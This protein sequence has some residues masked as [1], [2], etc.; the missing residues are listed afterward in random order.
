[1]KQN[2]FKECLLFGLQGEKAFN[3]R[4][5]TFFKP[6]IK[7]ILFEKN[8]NMQRAG[9][10]SIIENKRLEDI[11]LEIK[12]RDKTYWGYNDILLETI[13]NIKTHKKGWIHSF[14]SDYL[15]YFWYDAIIDRILDAYLLQGE[16]L[17]KWVTDGNLKRYKPKQ[18]KSND[19]EVE[20][21]TEFVL[22]PISDFHPTIITRV[23]KKYLLPFTQNQKGLKEF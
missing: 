19:N 4:G 17:R 8:P 16:L 18:T 6:I 9:I 14:E 23:D 3:E 13:S 2:N 10:D 5:I 21:I 12:T 1:M 11:S 15:V 22:V 20:W 7:E